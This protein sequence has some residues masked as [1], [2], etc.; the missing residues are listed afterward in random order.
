LNAILEDWVAKDVAAA[1]QLPPGFRI[2]AGLLPLDT[3]QAALGR[4]NREQVVSAR[5]SSPT[6][7]QALELTNGALLARSIQRGAEHW[8]EQAASDPPRLIDQVYRTAL[9]RPPTPAE[10]QV[11]AGI[12]GTPAT[13]E[14]I[15]DLLWTICMLPEFQLVP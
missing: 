1:A 8:R 12:V 2:R 3:L 10:L 4:P 15:E 9:S 11:A 5:D 13:I 6:M 14:G 7:L